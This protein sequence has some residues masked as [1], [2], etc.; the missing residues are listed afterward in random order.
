MKK[1]AIRLCI[2]GLL[3]LGAGLCYAAWIHFTE[4]GLPCLF[5]LIT[6]WQCPGCGISHMCMALLRFEFPA[7]FAANPAV[8]LLLP[9]W[10]VVFGLLALQYIRTGSKKM[11]RWQ[12]AAIIFSIVVLLVFGVIRNFPVF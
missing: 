12:N 4:A 2:W 9:L 1:R 6:G 8:L 3:F 7:A 11:S 5:R 10:C